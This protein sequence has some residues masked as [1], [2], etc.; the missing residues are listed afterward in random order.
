MELETIYLCMFIDKHP[1]S[2]AP[3][4]QHFSHSLSVC[5][6][7]SMH[8]GSIGPVVVHERGCDGGSNSVPS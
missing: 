1:G 2:C 5:G 4:T 7:D 3:A 6:G 8:Q